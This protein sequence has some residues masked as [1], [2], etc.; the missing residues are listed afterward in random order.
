MSRPSEI[1]MSFKVSTYPR[2]NIKGIHR[3]L[4]EDDIIDAPAPG[5]DELPHSVNIH[6][7]NTKAPKS[8]N[9]VRLASLKPQ[10]QAL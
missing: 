5:L 1:K 8:S 2:Y 7:T 10:Q 9:T 6:L 3:F 4:E